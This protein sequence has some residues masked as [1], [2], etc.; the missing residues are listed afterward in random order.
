MVTN[1]KYIDLFSGIGGFRHALELYTKDNNIQSKC[2]GYSE[3][4]KFAK[5]S[6]NAIYETA[7]EHDIGDLSKFNYSNINTL[8]D[9]DFITG[10]FPCQP[11]SILGSL[12]GLAD[13][14]GEVVFNMLDVI[15]VKQPKY[16][17]LE[18]VRN[19]KTFSNGEVYTQIINELKGFGYYVTSDLFNTSNYGLPQTRRRLFILG[20]RKDINNSKDL[21]SHLITLVCP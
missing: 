8:K 11:Y 20:V 13:E 5:Q 15:K 6:Y 18:N 10:G 9:V 3:I 1:I 12:T 16:F 14:R 2:V 17:L 21:L 19:F 4:D 7:N